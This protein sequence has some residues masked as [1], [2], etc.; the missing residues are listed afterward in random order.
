MRFLDF[1]DSIELFVI[2]PDFFHSES[3]VGTVDAGMERLD[4][5][6]LQTELSHN[7]LLN[8][9]CRRRRQSD[10]RWIADQRA[11]FPEASVIRAEIMPPFADA[12]SLI[13]GQKTNLSL[14]NRLNEFWFSKSLWGHIQQKKFPLSDRFVPLFPFT[15][16]Q[17]RIDERRGDPARPKSVD[18]IL[19]Q[20]N[21]WGKDERQWSL[22]PAARIRFRRHQSGNLIAERLASPSRHNDQRMFLIDNALNHRFLD[23]AE[24]VVSKILSQ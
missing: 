20:R 14:G 13:D 8:L 10:C 19:H 7:V 11:E 16:R 9:E 21:Q 18:L 22:P 4:L 5:V 15:P 3:Q 1:C 17:R 2:S 23:R 24:L 6:R 12:M